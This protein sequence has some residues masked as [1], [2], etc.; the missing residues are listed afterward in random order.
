M[1]CL[2]LRVQPSSI[3]GQQGQIQISRKELQGKQP[4][5]G[6]QNKAWDEQEGPE[7]TERQKV[8]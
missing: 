1:P 5:R 2:L 4:V 6:P 8:R 3:R 7:Q